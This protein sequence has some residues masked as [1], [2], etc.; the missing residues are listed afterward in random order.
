MLQVSLWMFLI[1]WMDKLG[2]KVSYVSLVFDAE[3][4]NIVTYTMVVS[5]MVET[6]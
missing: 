2:I 3:L 6:G 5:T 4:Q 1:G